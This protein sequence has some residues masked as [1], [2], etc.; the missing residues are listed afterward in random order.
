LR[1]LHAKGRV[2][3]KRK[4]VCDWI[5]RNRKWATCS[6]NIYVSHS[7]CSGGFGRKK[8][9]EGWGEIGEPQF[10]SFSRQN[11]PQTAARQAMY[12]MYI[13]ISKQE[14]IFS[15]FS[16]IFKHVWTTPV[17]C[18]LGTIFVIRLFLLFPMYARTKYI[19][20]QMYILIIFTRFLSLHIFGSFY[21]QFFLNIRIR[22]DY[23]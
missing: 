6:H 5:N 13:N 16:K 12:H 7:L 15:S 3:L 8:E 22:V 17:L 1:A 10:L 9:G 14:T 19:L 18:E 4:R 2:R 21:F 11:L 20:N 23:V